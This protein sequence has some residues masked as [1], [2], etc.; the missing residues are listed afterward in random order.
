MPMRPRNW[1]LDLYRKRTQDLNSTVHKLT[2]KHSLK[3]KLLPKLIFETSMPISFSDPRGTWHSHV[4]SRQHA[5]IRLLPS[6]A[7]SMVHGKYWLL[8]ANVIVASLMSGPKSNGT[9]SPSTYHIQQQ[10]RVSSW[11]W[12][13]VVG[14]AA[15]LPDGFRFS[16]WF[17][18][19]PSEEHVLY[20]MC[21]YR[22]NQPCIRYKC[23]QQRSMVMKARP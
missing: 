22:C 17:L 4:R 18:T 19:I 8:Y 20:I 12:D 13:T 1:A 9:D 16:S 11:P 10:A 14:P 15:A 6:T 23:L 3:L 5:T 21:L 2:A 7:V